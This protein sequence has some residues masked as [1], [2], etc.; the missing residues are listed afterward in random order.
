MER[1][2]VRLRGERKSKDG[3]RERVILRR[4]RGSVRIVGRKRWKKRNEQR[5]RKSRKKAECDRCNGG[6]K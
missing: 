2:R 5:S 1:K 3:V 4:E 6:K